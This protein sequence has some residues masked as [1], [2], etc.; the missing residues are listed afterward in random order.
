MA[1][2]PQPTPQP[3][4]DRRLDLVASEARPAGRVDE[5]GDDQVSGQSPGANQLAQSEGA[6]I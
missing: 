1:R 2:L 4:G 5:L 3:A 6:A